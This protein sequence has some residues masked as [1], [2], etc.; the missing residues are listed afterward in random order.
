MDTAISFEKYNKTLKDNSL[1]KDIG[2]VIGVRGLVIRGYVPASSIG[3][4][5]EVHTLSGT[6]M[7]YAEVIGFEGEEV[8]LMPLGIMQGI[9]HGSKIVLYKSSATVQVGDELL[10]RVINGLGQ[11]IDELAPLTLSEEIPLYDEAETPL[12]RELIRKPLSVGIRAIDGL[13]TMGQGQRMAIMAGSGVGKS[14]LLGQMARATSADINVI[15][16]IGERGRE[17]KEFIEH[18][19]GSEG[20]KKSVILAVTSDQSALV[21]MRGAFLATSIAE[22]FARKGKNVLFIMDS[23]TRFAMAQREIGLSAGEPPSSKG[24]T[25]S[26]FSQLP[27]LLERAGNFRGAGSITGIYSVLVEGDDMDEPIADAVRSIVDGHIVL[28]RKIAQRA[29]FPAID[30]LQSTSRVMRSV[31]TPD[32]FKVAQLLKENLAVYRDAEDLINIGAYKSGANPRIDRA[33]QS[34]DRIQDFLKQDV[35]EFSTY[36]QT[37]ALLPMLMGAR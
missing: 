14:M 5:C 19:F 36:Q 25:P 6:D 22:Y 24:Y 4:I 8:L 7:Q 2:K 33:V 27:K 32:H 26:V 18:S 35:N 13:L 29:H 16:M 20:L 17:V 28:D 10:G 23:V 30:I 37:V 31:T 11:P 3:S 12:R 9:G 15:A 21:R 1:K 34:I